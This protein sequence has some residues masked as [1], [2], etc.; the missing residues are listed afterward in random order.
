MATHPPILSDFPRPFL[1]AHRGLS[2]QYPENTIAAFKAAKDRGVPGIELDVH[3]VQGGR[4]LVFHDDTTQ[5]IPGG[6]VRQIETENF[7]ALRDLDIGAWKGPQF[8]GQIMPLLEEVLEELGKDMYFDIEIKSRTTGDR[9]LESRLAACLSRHAMKRRIP[10]PFE[11]SSSSGPGYPP[12]SFGRIGR[13]SIGFCGG[14]RDVS[15]PGWTSSSPSGTSRSESLR[16]Y[17]TRR[18]AP[19]REGRCRSSHGRWIR[20]TKEPP[21]WNLER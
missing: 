6:L 18:Y 4:L 13:N 14:G 15:W 7:D 19:R 21:S 17:G 10:F 8:A 3:L 12:P 11:D 1:F 2:S 9:G 16:G 5:R 20:P